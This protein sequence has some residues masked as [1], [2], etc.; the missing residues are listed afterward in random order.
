[1]LFPLIIPLGVSGICT[2]FDKYKHGNMMKIVVAIIYVI[3][4]TVIF[5][6]SPGYLQ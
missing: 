3:T 5:L 4:T 6:L 2:F 1:L